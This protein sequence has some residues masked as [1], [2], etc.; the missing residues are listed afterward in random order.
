MLN[1][2]GPAESWSFLVSCRGAESGIEEDRRYQRQRLSPIPSLFAA[3]RQSITLLETSSGYSADA[4][5]L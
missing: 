3:T 5:D 1:K 4:A 2:K